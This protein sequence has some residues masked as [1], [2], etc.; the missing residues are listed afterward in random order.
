M[1][2]EIL[3]VTHSTPSSPGKVKLDTAERAYRWIS[4]QL[5]KE[6][7]PFE[8]VI[9]LSDLDEQ[10]AKVESYMT[11]LSAT[12]EDSPVGHLFINGKH[13]PCGGVSLSC[14]LREPPSSPLALGASRSK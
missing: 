3:K 9:R 11:R 1:F 10:M 14:Y 6:L 8:Q 4:A 13:T 12:R 5:D 7:L 2:L